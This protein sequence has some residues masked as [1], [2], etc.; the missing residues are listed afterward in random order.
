M[1]LD[2]LKQIKTGFNSVILDNLPYQSSRTPSD[3]FFHKRKETLTRSET[4]TASSRFECLVDW[5]CRIHRCTEVTLLQR[6][7]WIITLNNLMVIG[8]V[9]FYGISTIVDYLMPY[10]HHHHIVPPAWISLTLSRHFSLSFI[11]SDRSSGLHPVSSHSC[12]FELV[13]LLLPGHMWGSIGVHHL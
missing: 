3:L 11:D 7:S 9:Y 10:H 4:L 12:M 6:V 2:K 1:T 5:G 8:L 13:I